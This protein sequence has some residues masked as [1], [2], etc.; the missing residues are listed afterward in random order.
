LFFD[1]DHRRSVSD[2]APFRNAPFGP[3]A[4][5]RVSDGLCQDFSL[6]LSGCLAPRF[7]MEARLS[8]GLQPAPEWLQEIFDEWSS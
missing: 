5:S 6:G 2:G 1:E 4:V 3:V 7:R 8:Q